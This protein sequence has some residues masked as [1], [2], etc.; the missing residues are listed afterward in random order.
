[1]LKLDTGPHVFYAH[2]Q[3]A[4]FK[5]ALGDHVSKGQVLAVLGNSGNSS[6]PHLH[7]HVS[8]REHPVVSESVPYVLERFTYLGNFTDPRFDMGY[9][10]WGK[11]VKEPQERVL[12]AEDEA[13]TF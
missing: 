13:F 11:Q 8:D 3:P 6:A 1:V 9:V 12:P 7:L 2:I 4:G 5:V 10:D